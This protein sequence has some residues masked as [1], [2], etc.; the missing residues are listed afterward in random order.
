ML[1]GFELVTVLVTHAALVD[2]MMDEDLLRAMQRL[3]PEEAST[4]S[5]SADFEGQGS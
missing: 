1:G 3:T 4:R 5:A 2:V